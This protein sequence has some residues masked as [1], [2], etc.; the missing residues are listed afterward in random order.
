[1]SDVS[2]ATREIAAYCRFIRSSLDR[3]VGCLAGLDQQQVNWRP[4]A[5]QANS[6]YA[7]VT[8]TLGNAEENLLYTLRGQPSQRDR[9]G[10]FAASAASS[11][12]IETRWLTLRAQLIATLSH[13]P[14]ADLDREWRH[15]RRGSLTGRE[16]VL[17]VARHSA[18]HPGQA[19]LTRDFLLATRP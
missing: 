1:M 9:E 6:L 19:E 13:L 7:I 4:L 15:P 16:I 5:P 3:L 8:H 18:E 10:E 11:L 17:V 2:F 14:P 12:P